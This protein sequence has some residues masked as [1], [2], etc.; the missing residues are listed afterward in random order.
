MLFFAKQQQQQFIIHTIKNIQNRENIFGI[1]SDK[2][3]KGWVRTIEIKWQ[4]QKKRQKSV[5]KIP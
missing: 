3:P 4:Q 5:D 2:E 1:L